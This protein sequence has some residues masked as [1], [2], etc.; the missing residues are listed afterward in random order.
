MAASDVTL[1]MILTG[2]DRSASRALKGVGS[3]AGKTGGKMSK[4][5][6]MGKVAM[7]G[8]AGALIGVGIAAGKF[9][10]DSVK[11]YAD[12]E[13]SQAKLEDAYKRFPK[14]SDVNIESLRKYN[15]ELQRKTGADADDV[16]ASQANLAMFGLTGKQIKATTPLLVDYANKTG[17]SMPDAAKTMG[18]ALLGNTKALK[19]MGISYKSTGDPAKDYANIMGLLKDKVGGYTASLPEAETKSKILA[20]SFGDLQEKV[21]AKLQPALI[22][23]TDAGIGMLDWLDQNPEVA[24]GASAAFELLGGALS[25]LWDIIRAY[26]LPG[27]AFLVRGFAMTLDGI[28]TMLYALGQIPGFE[29]AT[30]AAGKLQKMK[31][32][33]LA[34][35]DGM[36]ELGKEKPKPTVDVKGAAE[37]KVKVAKLDTQIKSLKGKMVEAKA[38]GDTKE[39]ERLRGRINALRGKK[40]DINAHVSKSGVSTIKLKDI[41][42][43]GLKISAYRSGGRPP[44]GQIA[45]FHKDEFWVP[46][47]A[48]TV[49]SQNRS[50]SMIG[51]GPGS[52]GSAGMSVGGNTYNSFT[53]NGIL[54]EAE[55]GRVFESAMN[56]TSRARGGRGFRLP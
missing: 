38:K 9:G 24:A 8:I 10:A 14:V 29:W 20:A 27:L 3:E 30:T 31:E 26:V 49:I 54:T 41:G 35:A 34:V 43:G 11:A 56:K 6:G 15:Q 47:V 16:A 7:L 4:F 42:A 45:Q 46:D 22:A 5:A 52:M 55:A 19:D 33:V 23:L 21:G 40:V 25:G 13:K 1:R 2:D 44:V 28:E 12:A 53:F 39:V 17:K 36:E 18:K 48:G 32:G 51:A 37:A 50:R